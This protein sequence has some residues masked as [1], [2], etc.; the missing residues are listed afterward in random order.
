L[1]WAYAM[2]AA[3]KLG[4]EARAQE[5]WRTL[6]SHAQVNGVHA[7][8][9]A[10]TVYS[11]GLGAEAESLWWRAAD[12][13]GKIS[14]DAL[15]SLARHYQVQRDAEGQYRV[16]R[17]L[18]SLRPQDAAVGNNFAFFAALT[19][20]EQAAA[21]KIARANL[22]AEP[23]NLTYLATRAFTLLQGNRADD[24]LALLK[25][26]ANEA[27]RSPAL[28]FVYGLALAGTGRQ[29]EARP[30]L[31]G[32]PPSTLTLREVELIKSSLRN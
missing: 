16:F 14:I 22:T 12:Q 5:L 21:E 11:W 3:R 31:E 32:L 9:A 29:E 18:H 23:A 19:G 17:R 27:T 26:H 15:G 25:P 4:D 30:L 10:A 24:A 20:R 28:G 8:F 13:E 2:Q 7:L 6:D 1:R